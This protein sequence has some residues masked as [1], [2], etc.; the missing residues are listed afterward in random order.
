VLPSTYAVNALRPGLEGT[1]TA[2]QGWNLL[3]LAAFGALSFWAVAGPL[4]PRSE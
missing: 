2:S 3:V 1:M 4:W